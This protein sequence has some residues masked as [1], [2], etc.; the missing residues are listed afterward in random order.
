M[1]IFDEFKAMLQSFNETA[2]HSEKVAALEDHIKHVRSS[3]EEV[4]TKALTDA[5]AAFEH[6]AELCQKVLDSHSRGS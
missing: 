1:S 6:A 4:L 2:E 3:G 5:K